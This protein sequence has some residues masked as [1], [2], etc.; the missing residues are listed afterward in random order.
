MVPDQSG[1]TRIVTER[2]DA[3]TVSR[4]VGTSEDMDPVAMRA[5]QEAILAHSGVLASMSNGKDKI[6]LVSK[7]S[8]GKW[9]NADEKYGDTKPQKVVIPVQ[10][11]KWTSYLLDNLYVPLGNC[12]DKS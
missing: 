3:S 7:N 8:A 9:I 6:L 12:F 11:E 2:I 10:F 4:Q 5:K 1:R